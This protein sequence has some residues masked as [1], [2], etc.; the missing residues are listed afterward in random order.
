MSKT[1]KALEEFLFLGLSRFNGVRIN[2]LEKLSG[3]AACK[4]VDLKNLAALK[5]NLLFENNGR[6]ILKR[7]WNALINSILLNILVR[8]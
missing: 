4:Y 6:I 2:N 8:N 1:K 7:K 5:K 3:Y